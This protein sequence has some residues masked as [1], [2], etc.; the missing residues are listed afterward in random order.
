[1][2][3][4]VNIRTISFAAV[5]ALLLTGCASVASIVYPLNEQA[6]RAKAGSYQLDPDHASVLFS[7]NHFGF[8]EFRGRFDGVAGSMDL[9]NDA[10]ENSA[11]SVEID[12]RSLHTGVPEL[13]DKL[14][15]TNMF[16]ADRF[17]TASFASGSITRTSESTA[18]VEGTLTINGATQLVQLEARFIGSGTNPLSGRQTIGFTATATI[19]RSDFGLSEWLPFVRDEVAL[20]IDA[21]FFEKR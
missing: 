12:V 15:A 14:L 2:R 18:T 8:S 21:E 1:M 7:V 6:E 9:D 3:P 11:V 16:D 10:P 4:F 17:P 5:A 19:R 13:D 20:T